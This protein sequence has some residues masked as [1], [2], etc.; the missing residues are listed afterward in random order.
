MVRVLLTENEAEIAEKAVLEYGK[1]NVYLAMD[2]T[3]ANR[4]IIKA[5]GL[6]RYAL[7]GADADKSLYDVVLPLS[8]AKKKSKPSK[9]AL[10]KEVEAVV[11]EST[12]EVF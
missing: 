11:D 5:L 10:A 3:V 7:V 4:R 1:R 6:D 2:E 8:P 9:K 12:K